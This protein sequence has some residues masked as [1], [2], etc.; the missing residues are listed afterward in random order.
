[1]KVSQAMHANPVCVNINESMAKIAKQMKE[2]DFGT[3]IVLEGDKAQGI[4]TDRDM[5]V[6]AIASGL[7]MTTITAKDIMSKKLES[8]NA[9]DSISQA[10]D[11]MKNKKIRRLIVLDANSKPVGILSLGDIAVSASNEET[12]HTFDALKGVSKRRH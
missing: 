10:A 11:K 8:C 9:T 6:R 4:I 5:V 12:G 3:V 1:M 7:D 2:G